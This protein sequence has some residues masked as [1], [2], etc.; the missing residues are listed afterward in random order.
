MK[1]N[2]NQSGVTKVCGSSALMAFGHMTDSGAD[3]YA[4]AFGNMTHTLVIMQKW[5]KLDLFY[6]EG[7]L[8][9]HHA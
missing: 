3:W 7:G 1:N 9:K 5:N 2:K 6:A 8:W 4:N